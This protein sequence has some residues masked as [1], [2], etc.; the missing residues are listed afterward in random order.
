MDHSKGAAN[1]S[2]YPRRVLLRHPDP[3]CR[4]GL[5][6]ISVEDAVAFAAFALSPFGNCTPS[7][8]MDSV[9]AGLAEHHRAGSRLSPQAILNGWMLLVSGNFNSGDRL[10]A[11]RRVRDGRS[12]CLC[13]ADRSFRNGCVESRGLGGG[14]KSLDCLASNS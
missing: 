3:E 10:G 11:G 4:R 1:C 13:S 9:R 2:A 7:M 6:V 12:L 5:W 14:E 8:A